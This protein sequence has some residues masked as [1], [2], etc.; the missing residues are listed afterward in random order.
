LLT[1]LI[2]KHDTSDKDTVWP[3]VIHPDEVLVHEGQG[4]MAQDDRI[5]QS[6]GYAVSIV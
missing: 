2:G 6:I 3:P 5:D 4:L 1:G